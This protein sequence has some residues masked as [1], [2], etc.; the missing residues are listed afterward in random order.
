MASTSTGEI[1]M[2]STS[3]GELAMTSTPTGELAM[4]SLKCISYGI[5]MKVLPVKIHFVEST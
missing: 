1:A 3:T 5:C 4:A 2:A